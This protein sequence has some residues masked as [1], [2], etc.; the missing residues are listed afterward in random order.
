MAKECK[1]E[2]GNSL[3]TASTLECHPDGCHMICIVHY[4]WQKIRDALSLNISSLQL[5]YIINMTSVL[6][7]LLADGIPHG[8]SRC[9][10]KWA[11]QRHLL[12]SR[13]HGLLKYFR[14]RFSKGYS[15]RYYLEKAN[16]CSLN[17]PLDYIPL[18]VPLWQPPHTFNNAALSW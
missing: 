12:K 15:S 2:Q 9:A 1:H 13:S 6:V 17:D 4:L 16:T 7:P 14:F 5:Y 11:F 10:Y 3:Q 8:H 18:P